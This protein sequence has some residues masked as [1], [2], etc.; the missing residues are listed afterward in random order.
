[1]TSILDAICAEKRREVARRKAV[2]DEAAVA[3]LAAHAAPPRGFA[4]ALSAALAV[5]GYGLIAELKKGSPSGGT[6]R[7]DFDPQD[8]ARAYAAGGAACLSV[9][10]DQP[11]FQGCD[12]H[13]VAARAAVTLPVLR[14][15]FILEPYQVAEARALGA[16]CILLI[17]AALD[18]ATAGALAAR[19]HGLGMDVLIEIHDRG[20]LERALALDA[21]LIG[22]NNRNLKTLSV[23]LRTTEELAPLVPTDRIVVSESGLATPD[24]LARMAACGARCF[25]IGSALM[26]AADVA[27]ATRA[28][29]APTLS[30]H[31][32]PV[33]TPPPPPRPR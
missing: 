14:K 4:R 25:L 19:A 12:Q 2:R 33:D 16:D 13:L 18:D 9:L 31:D 27:Q 8:L 20:E 10:T 21:G 30:T 28:L 17:L 6:I 29:L 3:T 32:Q 15:D 26:R 5:G 23:D 24:D 1:M 7:A 11:Y 22:I